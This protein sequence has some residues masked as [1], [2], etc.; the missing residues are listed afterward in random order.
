MKRLSMLLAIVVLSVPL[1]AQ[2]LPN[3]QPG[4]AH[5][6]LAK[7]AG[8]WD[9]EIKMYMQGPDG[10]PTTYTGVETNELVSGGLF[11][12]SVFKA[13]MGDRDY[14]GHGLNGYDGNSKEY[15]SLW[16]DSLNGAPS[17]V[18]GTYDPAKK[19]LTSLTTV[20]DPAGQE[21]KQKMVT[22]Y[23]DDRTREFRIFLVLDLGGQ[24]Q[25][26]KLMEMTLKKRE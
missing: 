16:A 22:R 4:E 13:R 3:P 7:D 24:T 2:E 15:V 17:V 26:L 1:Y 20:K 8:T 19:E 9:A 14:E 21:L 18:K 6:V 11:S 10:P 25:E 5:K 23:V 12:R